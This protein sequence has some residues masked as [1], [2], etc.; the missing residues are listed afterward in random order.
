MKRHSFLPI[1]A[2]ALLGFAILVV[3]SRSL[4]L[5]E[6]KSIEL[7]FQSEINR[8]ASAFEREVTLNLEIL[9]TL[10][11]AITV[12]PDI[13]GEKFQALTQ[14]LLQRST[15]IKAFALAPLISAENLTAFESEQQRLNPGLRLV[16]RNAEGQL[17]AVSDR[18]WYVPVQY[19]QPIHKNQSAL[20]FDLASE[21]HRLT[22]LGLARESGRMV[23]TAGINL[24]QIP[25]DQLGFLVFAPLYHGD[26]QSPEQRLEAHFGFING[27]FTLKALA[28]RSI[29]LQAD[30]N[31]LL[32][33]L[34]VTD[35][36]AQVLYI[37]GDAGERRWVE[38]MNHRPPPL[39]LA[40]RNWSVE[41]MPA[42]DYVQQKRGYL[43]AMIMVSGSLFIALLVTYALIS[44]NRNK[45]LGK[46]KNKLEKI[47]L[48]DSLTELAN[49]RH[50]DVFLRQEWLR[51]RRQG[52]SLALVMLDIDYFKPFNDEY[53][54]PAGD[55]CLRE[56]A[57]TLQN[58]V[59]RPSDLLARYG[60]EEFA[61]ILPATDNAQAVAESCRAAV[62]ALA[63]EHA[64][65]DT[66]NVVTISAGFYTL[67]PDAKLDADALKV[68]ADEALY[69]AK[70]LGRNQIVGS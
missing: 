58:V 5:E 1:A 27:V 40:R 39:D 60:G 11:T 49:R 3:M 26:P 22:A 48:T 29:G 13:D 43:P 25:H 53:G 15:A 66:S 63:I 69:R 70:H 4:Y 23:A 51:A 36:G 54:H 59:R 38:A 47:S 61:I 34:D 45:A 18:P 20:G 44:L 8:L 56:V 52:T 57:K 32:R 16:E 37:S 64:F 35:G 9:Y 28:N 67:L 17:V 2:L 46:A 68:L 50:F 24:V 42:R 30:S 12:F 55:D 6:S 21:Q 65:S 33:I 62:E 14:N 10:K 19:I 41:A 31:I 7:E